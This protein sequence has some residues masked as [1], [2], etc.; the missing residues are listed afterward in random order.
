MTRIQKR[1]S[2]RWNS[3]TAEFCKCGQAQIEGILKILKDL[4]D[5]KNFRRLGKEIHGRQ[6]H[7]VEEEDLRSQ[8]CPRTGRL[9]PGK[10]LI[11]APLNGLAPH[12]DLESF[13]FPKSAQ[14]YSAILPS[15]K[16]PVAARPGAINVRLRRPSG[17]DISEHFGVFWRPNR[18]PRQ[19]A[20]VGVVS[21]FRLSRF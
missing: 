14:A 6:Q 7:F 4:K 19:S 5:A 9:V 17:K 12:S 16:K 20:V 1:N 10:I 11:S 18:V 15:S 2:H 8:G 21:A 3:Q 13:Q